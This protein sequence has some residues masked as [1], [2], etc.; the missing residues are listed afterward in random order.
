[1]TQVFKTT[2]YTI[3]KLIDDIEIGPDV[4]IADMHKNFQ[5]RV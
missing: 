2:D 3:G 4:D 1:M 5:V